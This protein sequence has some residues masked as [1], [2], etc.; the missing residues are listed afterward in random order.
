[1]N[2]QISSKERGLAPFKGV[3]TDRLPMWYGG[4]PET[5]M[6][7]MKYLGAASEEEALYEI[8]GMDYKTFRPVYTGKPFEKT[9]DG[10][11]INE[12]GLIRDGYHWGQAIN[13]PLENV[14]SVREI[15]NYNFPKSGDFDVNFTNEQLEE[16]GEYCVIGGAWAPYFHDAAELMGMERYLFEMLMNPSLVE[17]LN[18]KCFDFYYELTQNAF[19]ANPGVIDFLFYG[20]DFGTQHGMMMSPE[21]WRRFYKPHMVKLVELAHSHGAICGLHSCGDIHEIF[22]DMIDAGLDVINPIQV[23]C[24]GMVPEKLK[25]EYGKDIVFFGGVDENEILRCGTETEVREETKRIIDILGSDGK[26]IVAC[27]HD[28]LLPEIPAENIVAMYDEAAKYSG[29]TSFGDKMEF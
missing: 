25:A 27:T 16:A 10:K 9:A 5:T 7:I 26:L 21:N 28:Y 14:T 4:A 23:S 8:L 6:N 17:A 29:T 20:N 3:F 18:E 15:E 11:I 13:S 2:K 12:W 1:M 22:P 19:D 24:P